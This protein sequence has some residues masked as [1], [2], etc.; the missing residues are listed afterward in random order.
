MT[1]RRAPSITPK[2]YLVVGCGASL[3]A[4]F[5]YLSGLA[6]I[7][8]FGLNAL[9]TTVF[10]NVV[11]SFIIALFATLSGPDGRWLVGPLGRQ[12]VMAGLCGG[13]TTFSAMSLD[14]F[15][16]LLHDSWGVAVFYLCGTVI[17]SLF[18]AWLGHVTAVFI[19]R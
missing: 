11:G 5:R 10:V 13:F 7:G 2:F 19:N 12:F 17:G 8:A 1:E 15:L 3:G 14:T 18:S 6:I 9:W 4:G 16:L